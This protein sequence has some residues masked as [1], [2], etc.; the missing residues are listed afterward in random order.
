MPI[1]APRRVARPD[2]TFLVTNMMRS[3]INEGTG[4]GRAR[5][6]LRPRRGGQDRHDQRPARR[7]VRRLHAGTA[8]RRL[9]RLR[10]QS[11]ARPERR[12]GGAA[13][14]DPVH[15]PGAGRP[16]RSCRSPSPRAS[17]GSRSTGTPASSRRPACPRVIREAF[18]AGTE[19][20]EPCELHS[21][22]SA[23]TPDPGR[24]QSAPIR[25]AHRKAP[26]SPSGKSRSAT[27]L[28]RRVARHAGIIAPCPRNC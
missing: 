19:P 28:D 1:A 6:R 18:L 26:P 12:P 15:D 22:L 13:D 16:R 27:A 10:R 3:V 25:T 24:P 8:D 11:A 21:V 2:T 17:P 23:G 20:L 7:L 9:G 14:L 5:L 4:G